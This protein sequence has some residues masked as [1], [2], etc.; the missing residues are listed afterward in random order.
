MIQKKS[1]EVLLLEI[2][3]MHE[4]KIAESSVGLALGTFNGP[5]FTIPVDTDKL[6]VKVTKRGASEEQLEGIQESFEE[7]VEGGMHMVTY[8]A[9][10]EPSCHRLTDAPSV[11]LYVE[12]P[13][14]KSYA[15]NAKTSNGELEL[16]A[17]KG[18]K[19]TAFTSNGPLAFSD[20]EFDSINLGT[21][22]GRI[23]GNLV[24]EST[25]QTSNGNISV[26]LEGH[27]DYVLRTSNGKIDVLT[28]PDTTT[29]IDARTSNGRIRCEVYNL[30]ILDKGIGRLK[31]R[32]KGVDEGKAL[33]NLRLYTSNGNIAIRSKKVA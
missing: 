2:V 6:S 21:S 18:S 1:N 24:G 28:L 14:D 30:A 15:L 7:K 5:I 16:G 26:E 9:K 8:Y 32:T 29:E 22:N 27:G 20:I 13:I 4:V 10:Y 19:L 31:A 23:S 11:S 17:L 12:T 25:L 3:E 33:I